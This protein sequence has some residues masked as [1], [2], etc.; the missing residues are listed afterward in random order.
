[1]I[2]GGSL[3]DLSAVTVTAL[4]TNNFSTSN[5]VITSGNV[6]NIT[7]ANLTLANSSIQ[8][9]TA[10]TRNAQDSS[11]AIAT[12]AFVHSVIPIGV[13]LMWGGSVGT[14]P[15]GWQLCNG[16][17]GTP[18]LRDRFIVGAGTTYTPGNT[19]GS[20]SVTLDSTQ[21]PIHAHGLTGTFTSTAAGQHSHTAT[22]TDPGHTHSVNAGGTA[23]NQLV[24]GGT[25][26]LAG[27]STGSAVTGIGVS[28]ASVADHQHSITLTGN[29]QSSGGT[30]G[31]TQSHENR[32]PYYALCYIQKMY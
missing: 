16:S 32:P 26:N 25:V 9:S 22:V 10:T 27:S 24:N 14:I 20:N 5:A 4:Q 2:T 12:T 30:G 13:I 21:L 7:G 18:D 11:T 1:L 8:N 29:T 3:T 15:A 31:N 23:S 28:I 17:N 19:G 6:S